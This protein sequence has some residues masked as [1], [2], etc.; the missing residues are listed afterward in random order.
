MRP[1]PAVG[2]WPYNIGVT[3]DGRYL[4]VGN[5]IDSDVSILKVDGTKEQGPLHRE[6]EKA[7]RR[8]LSPAV[9]GTQ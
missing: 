6:T 5:F 8:S 3:P 7:A 2:Q 1:L 4:Y 9:M